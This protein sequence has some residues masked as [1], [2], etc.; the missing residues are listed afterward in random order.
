M[1]TTINPC[2]EFEDCVGYFVDDFTGKVNSK[3]KVYVS[4]L[5]AKIPKSKKPTSERVTI[6]SINQI[7]INDPSTMPKIPTNLTSVNYV[8]AFVSDDVI[9]KKANE[10]LYEKYKKE[11]PYPTPIYYIPFE[12]ELKTGT[13]VTVCGMNGSLTS[14]CIELD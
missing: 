3:A 14:L 11:L 4:N 1:L 2:W 10:D 13:E 7:C 8:E 6:N 5:M 12:V 9:K